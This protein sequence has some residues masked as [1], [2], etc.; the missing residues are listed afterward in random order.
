[1]SQ[2]SEATETARVTRSSTNPRRRVRTSENDTLKTSAPRR[3][4]SKISADQ[5]QP[6]VSTEHVDAI[7]EVE[8][9]PQAN[10][11]HHH[12]RHAST[13]EMDVVV[14]GKKPA[15]KRAMRGDGATVLTSNKC[16]SVRLLPSTP[17]ELRQ[18][19]VEYRGSL[20][21]NGRALAVTREKAIIWEYHAHNTASTPRVFDIPFAVKA[22]EELP[23]GALVPTGGVSSTDSGLM[24]IS[25][26]TGK[27]VYYESIDRETSI[28]RFQQKDNSVEGNLGLYS[29]EKLVDIVSAEH[30]GFVVLL[31]S[32]RTAQVALRD[33]QGKAKVTVNFLRVTEPASGSFFGSF[34][35]L[36]SSDYKKDVAAVHT[37]PLRARGQMQA[38]S[39]TE[40]GEI[41]TWELDWSGRSEYQAT[42]QIRD[43]VI[44]ELRLLG[45]PELEGRVEKLAALDFAILDKPIIGDG[46]EVA[47][48]SGE[49]H[50]PLDLMVLL[51]V[52]GKSMHN[53]AVAALTLSGSQVVVHNVK[54]ITKYHGRPQR[55]PKLIV[56][57]PEHSI[58]VVFEDATVL[59]ATREPTVDSPEAQLI[60][61]YIAPA[62]FEE[63]IF[64]RQGKNLAAQDVSAELTR[65]GSQASCISFVKSAGLVRYSSFDVHSL[66]GGCKLSAKTQIEEAVFY[67]TLQQ[68]NIIDFSITGGER[69]P[70]QDVEAAALEISDEILRADTAPQYISF[71]SQSP[72]S[73]EQGLATKGRALKALAGHLRRSY[74]AL[75][76]STMWR[77]LW[78]AE[79]VAAGQQLWITFEEHVAATSIGEKRKATLLDEICTWFK[80]EQFQFRSEF[81]NEDP[82]R[83]F[84]IGGLHHL[85]RVLGNVKLFLSDLKA[86]ETEHKA[87]EILKLANQANDVWYRGLDAAFVFRGESAADYG[88]LSE[89]LT[90]GV[91]TDPVE[92][93]DLPEFWTSTDRLINCTTQ[94]AEL[95][96]DFAS[97]YFGMNAL[98]ANGD[99]L[100]A[101]LA[102]ANIDL[103]KL[104]CLQ[105]Q[106]A[107]NWRK[108]RPGRQDQELAVTYQKRYAELRYDA[109]RSLAGVGQSVAGM[110]LA[111]KWRDMKTLTDMVVAEDQ[112]L[113]D[114][115]GNTSLGAAER[116]KAKQG[117][118][119]LK[120]QIRSHFEKFGEAWSEPFF[121]CMFHEGQIG[122][123]LESA[124]K[125]W[126]AA[127]KIWLRKA[128][129]RGKLCWINDVVA[130]SDFSHAS[131]VLQREGGKEE[132]VWAKKVELSLGRLA[133][134]AA[135]EDSAA[136]QQIIRGGAVQPVT[137][138]EQKSADPITQAL[139][140]I[141]SQGRLDAHILSTRIGSL[142]RDAEILNVM[143]RYSTHLDAGLV[144][145]H[146]L[147]ENGLNAVIDHRVLSIEQLVDVLTLIDMSDSSS[148]DGIPEGGNF[149]L[150]LQAIEA[151]IPTGLTSED[152]DVL[153]A[154]VWKRMYIYDDWNS[155]ARKMSRKKVDAQRLE[156][157]QDTALWSTV[158]RGMEE[159]IFTPEGHR[160]SLPSEVL[161][162][163]CREADYR[164]R[165]D[166]GDDM[167]GELVREE[168][169]MD[170]ILVGLVGDCG[171]E[172]LVGDC[173]NGVAAELKA[174]RANTN[175]NG[176]MNGYAN[177][178]VNGHAGKGEEDEMMF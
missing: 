173:V 94:I 106:E 148:P 42:A 116:E 122:A 97:S 158:R 38:V 156:V 12:Q 9:P 20:D 134:L 160:I 176:H 55:R 133:M 68:D 16:Y 46:N 96:R 127:L 166:L 87:D 95:S 45:I 140:L 17:K 146:T 50:Q 63:T 40:G 93:Q 151:A 175:G 149:S 54:Y 2:S 154:L 70:L 61:S 164:H 13:N 99:A 130:G 3:K 101:E 48:V 53:Y 59:L 51:S 167:L 105:S 43:H 32:G 110:E 137:L 14:R 143:N 114:C 29:G 104:L 47:V 172:G 142:D 18:E 64:L 120:V 132:E 62:P 73:M 49:T 80:E 37:R 76:K 60:T 126:P 113:V 5:F 108:S 83:K 150:A 119:E 136:D 69:Q 88:I 125:E 165:K 144:T 85:E 30:A 4:R 34:K 112:Y 90:D 71:I 78:D 91:L 77:L 35:G 84:F 10:G 66:P 26:T 174:E 41:L 1:M 75:P 72:P 117:L 25:A 82:V 157:L 139:K 171:L 170:E 19:G 57:K 27:V 109:L 111:E 7:V 121:E 22:R 152:A 98:D 58:F 24:L 56:P 65:G 141:E 28:G 89:H 102:R 123:K 115:A 155:L 86:D 74:P 131:E 128:D 177:G 147:L 159:K 135:E 92:Y 6:R 79:R 161:G 67:G 153:S 81:A 178:H 103:A 145:H 33:A 52:G 39:L 162:L 36:L 21:R 169:V 107:V 31:D 8:A 118:K 15:T 163:G 44:A 100:A 129:W 168:K 124:Q 138:S 23:F 11:V